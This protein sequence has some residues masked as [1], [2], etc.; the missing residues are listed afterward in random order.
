MILCDYC[1]DEIQ[2]DLPGVNVYNKDVDVRYVTKQDCIPVGFKCVDVCVKDDKITYLKEGSSL[3]KGFECVTVSVIGRDVVYARNQKLIPEGFEQVTVY[4]RNREV[5]YARQGDSPP[6]GFD[7]VST[8]AKNEEIKYRKAS[9]LTP[10]GFEQ[11]TVC[12]KTEDILYTR[13]EEL[14][15]KGSEPASV[16]VK[17]EDIADAKCY[18]VKGAFHTECL[19]Y[20]PRR[21]EAA[22]KFLERASPK[23]NVL[24]V[25]IHVKYLYGEGKV[26]QEQRRRK[27]E[28]RDRKAIELLRKVSALRN[29]SSGYILIHLVGLAPED[30][31]TGAFNE[32]ADPKLHDL[33][34]DEKQFSDVYKT[35]ALSCHGFGDFLVLYV[36]ASLNVTTS[37]FNTKTT[38]D[39]RIEDI[40]A[41]TLRTFARERKSLCN[42]F[43]SL[44][45]VTQAH[46]LQNVHENRSIQIKS[47]FSQK[48][49]GRA[50][51]EDIIKNHKLAEYISAFTKTECGGSFLY[52]VH[53]ETTFK[54]GYGYETKVNRIQP[55]ILK[56]RTIFRD[57]LGDYIRNTVLVCD[58]DGKELF[59]DPNIFLI[60]FIP[61]T[62]AGECSREEE[63]VYLRVRGESV[64][65]GHGDEDAV[66]VHVAVR[67]VSGIVFHDKQGPLAYR[68][69]RQFKLITRIDIKDWVR[70]LTKRRVTQK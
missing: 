53:E 61:C 19:N 6:T 64:H 43:H 17:N 35:E 37:K 15:P 50:I 65:D 24:S 13:Q 18:H 45:G 21:E 4:T 5:K 2:P 54:K 12:V 49:D 68:Y 20:I 16:Y 42:T 67:P 25:G 46:H 33:I 26:N 10:V 22:R 14:K 60:H 9:H 38:L 28:K 58:Y 70:A 63:K 56:D 31:F 52:G 41:E 47:H 66:V 36:G 8:Y 23:S 34:Q 27:K 62:P 69:D 3:P 7:Q 59:P 57:T 39:D 51:A 32:F 48:K 30:T 29:S 44:P 11:V 40:R 55:V 1:G